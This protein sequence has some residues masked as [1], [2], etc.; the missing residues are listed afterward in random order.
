MTTAVVFFSFV[1]N[2]VFGQATVETDLPDYSPGQVV[3]ISGTNWHPGET[4]SI[5][6][7]SDCG[8]EN[9]TY[10]VTAA[11]DS[12][13]FHTGFTLSTEHLGIGFTVTATGQTSLQVA[14][15]TFHDAITIWSN[16]ITS[17]GINPNTSNPYTT[18]DIIYTNA[19]ITVSGIG[20]G[21][22]TNGATTNNRYNASGWNS[23]SL[24]TND[25]YNFTITPNAGYHINYN[26]F[27]YAGQTS[28]TGPINFAFR[29]NIAGD[30]FATDIGTPT[31]AGA[32]IALNT[33]TYSNITGAIE[34]RLY[35]WN[36]SSAVGTFSVNDFTFGGAIL[37][38]SV[39][40]LNGF[41]TCVSTASTAQS[42]TSM[43]SDL[44]QIRQLQ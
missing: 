28:P 37:G 15:T 2:I 16:P 25:Y 19:N 1:T 10:Y 38:T 18:G 39:P 8:C 32:T 36:A 12:T 42:F 20:M 27:I 41:S 4:V 30:N 14:K 22:G 44:L 17:N 3:T 31:A 40:S 23:S 7:L 26:N 33:S 11:A 34:F 5:N 43:E 24:N 35:G 6:I 13:I 21:T 9:F 29:S